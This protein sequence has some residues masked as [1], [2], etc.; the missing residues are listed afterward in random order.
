MQM[1]SISK[2]FKISYLHYLPRY[3]GE[4]GIL[5]G[6]NAEV[7]LIF[8]KHSGQFNN[9]PGMILCFST[10]EMYVKPMLSK[11]LDKKNLMEVFQNFVDIEAENNFMWPLSDTGEKVWSTTPENIARFIID[12]VKKLPIGTSL[13][14]IR[15]WDDPDNCVEIYLDDSE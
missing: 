13:L 10:I 5:H 12:K 7:E 9:Y 6:H 1:E 14:G 3:T 11:Y 15:F 4:E 2:K 8:K